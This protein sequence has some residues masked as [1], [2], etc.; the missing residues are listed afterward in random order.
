MT[1]LAAAKK[2]L[3][4]SFVVDLGEPGIKEISAISGIRGIYVAIMSQ[5]NCNCKMFD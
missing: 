1:I 5:Y 2:R 4:I 3:R